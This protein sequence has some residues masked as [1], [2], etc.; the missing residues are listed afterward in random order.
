M[1]ELPT[2]C[3]RH[4]R[5]HWS[6]LR[7]SPSAKE[8]ICYD[9]RFGIARVLSQVSLA[10]RDGSSS[11]PLGHMLKLLLGVFTA[12]EPISIYSC[13][14][15]DPA[16]ASKQRLR[17]IRGRHIILIVSYFGTPTS[18]TYV[19]GRQASVIQNQLLTFHCGF[20]QICGLPSAFNKAPPW[21]RRRH[22]PSAWV[23][24]FRFWHPAR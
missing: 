6:N 2:G 4:S 11:E 24:R 14:F 20:G 15:I 18:I 12:S 7:P 3:R 23:T 1:E 8:L 10:R 19:S 22:H 17:Q 13:P 5:V 9:V 21:I 16:A